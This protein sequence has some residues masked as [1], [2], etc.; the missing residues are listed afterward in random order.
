VIP[1][2]RSLAVR[3]SNQCVSVTQGSFEADTQGSPLQ[4]PQAP[5][6]LYRKD[7]LLFLVQDYGDPN[8]GGLIM[9][10]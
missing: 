1:E 7:R 3:V 4:A 5:K 9:E 10:I 2:W 8:C 6:E